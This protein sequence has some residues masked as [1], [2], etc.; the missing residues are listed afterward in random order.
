MSGYQPYRDVNPASGGHAV[1]YELQDYYDTAIP[2]SF[3]H[4]QS[5][6]PVD[7]VLFSYSYFSGPSSFIWL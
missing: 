1:D 5:R 4:G 7:R 6:V 2:V 3:G